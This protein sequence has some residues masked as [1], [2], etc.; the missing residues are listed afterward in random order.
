MTTLSADAGATRAKGNA[1][2]SGHGDATAVGLYRW[3]VLTV[4]MLIYAFNFIDRQILTILAPYL[5]ADLGFTDAQLGLLFGTTFALFYGVLGIPL[6]KLADG[7]SRVKTLAIGLSFWSL[8]T[9]LSGMG[10]NFA[11]LGLARVGVGV[12][13][14]SAS[15]AAV[16][17][18]GDYFPKR[19]RATILALF[20]SG[21]YVGAG[22]SLMIGGVIVAN[23]D[24]AFGLKGWQAAFVIVGLP[25]LLLAAL[26]ALTIREPVRGGMDGEVP[27][28]P[29]A[30][31]FKAVAVEVA[32]MFPPWSI[33][34]LRRAGASRTTVLTNVFL[35]L[36][37]LIGAIV[38]TLLTDQLLSPSRRAPLFTLFGV[39]VTTNLVQWLALALAFYASASWV[40]GIRLRDPVAHRLIVATPAFMSMC[41]A[42]G[43]LGVYMFATNGFV[44]VYAT[45]YLG[46]GP[47][48][49]LTL[50]G[51][52]IVAGVGGM[53]VGGVIADFIKRRH[54]GGRMYMLMVMTTL[55]TASTLVQ[56]TTE[57]SQIFLLTYFTS[58]LVLTG[59]TPIMVATSQDLSTSRLRGT[60]MAVTALMTNVI[61]LGVGP[62][63][64]GF[65]SDATGDLRTGI[66]SVLL[67]VPATLG[68]LF[69]TARHLPEAERT[70]L[71]RAGTAGG[72]V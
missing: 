21:I 26:V 67:T 50:G 40:Q 22:V 61:G 30:R 20:S 32:S 36:G 16:S 62:Y 2:Q 70:I 59:W 23:W 53:A 51:I 52:S 9:T 14:A 6:A 72:D 49:G 47:D 46:F 55:F 18:L 27:P 13:E 34:S 45:R 44:F 17:L 37:A 65:V 48:M 35:L 4:M 15:P 31:P 7:W 19:M 8:M 56:F 54:P 29:I 71:I 25:G 60:A 24:G 1:D 42:C 64:V 11:H 5:K 10:T 3:Y 12:G 38:I 66:L 43:L 68:L 39:T 33:S 69:Y 58:L 57:N 41:A 28:P 63:V